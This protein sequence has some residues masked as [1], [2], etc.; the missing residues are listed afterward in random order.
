MRLFTFIL[1]IIVLLIGVSFAVLNANLV[2]LHYYF[3]ERQL[4]LSLL[5]AIALIL[6]AILGLIAATMMLLR[7]KAAQ[8]RLRKQLT[9]AQKELSNLRKIPLEHQ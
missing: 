9:M 4:P 6:G 8:H 5:L 7:A 2:S 1:A 3:G